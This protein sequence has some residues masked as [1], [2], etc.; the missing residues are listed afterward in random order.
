MTVSTHKQAAVASSA[1]TAT[2]TAADGDLATTN[3]F[4]EGNH[5]TLIS[6]DGTKRVYVLSDASE[7]GASATGVVLT[8]GADTGAGTLS[9][10]TAALGT[11]VAVNA[12]LNTAT[13]AAVVN[14]IKAAVVHANGHN[15][16]I[17]ASADLVAADGAQS[18]TFTQATAGATGNTTITSF[19][20]SDLV[21]VTNFTGGHTEGDQKDKHTILNGG[22]ISSAKGNSK[23][24]LDIVKGRKVSGSQLVI[25]TGT[26]YESGTAKANSSGTFGYNPSSSVAKRAINFAASAPD[27]GFIIR[28]GVVNKI[29]GT[30]LNPILSGGSDTTSRRSGTLP[31]SIHKYR[32]SG[33]WATTIFDVYGGNLLQSD[34]TAKEGITSRGSTVSLAADHAAQPTR[35]IPGE[36][37]L[38]FDFVTFT[39][40]NLDYS[41][42]TG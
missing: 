26:S 4:T 5:V 13:Q 16:A 31:P 15:G 28:S 23:S 9:A 17:T 35:A 40:N 2:I 18:I 21:T 36:M 19:L 24:L 34:G 8:A 42:I 37:T 7:S 33:T 29:A 20:D 27:S 14:A 6:Y 10:D 22:N 41:A 39:T 32:Q 3:Q 38:L 30:A 1:A 25:N 12:N 11:C